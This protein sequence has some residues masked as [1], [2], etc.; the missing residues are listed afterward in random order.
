MP[1]SYASTLRR[2]SHARSR[3]DR[4]RLLGEGLGRLLAIETLEDRSLLSVN[5]VLISDAV[6]QAQQIRAAAAP[7]T[8]AIVYDADTVS[9]TGLINLLT[10]VSATHNGAL[11]G[12]LGIVAHGGPGEIDLGKGEDLNLAT[13]RSQA[14][15]L[16]GIRSVLTS[17]AT[18]E[19]YSC[20]V[21]AGPD[22]KTFVN[23]LATV[24][25]AAVFASDN[26]VGTVPGANFTWDYRTGQTVASNVLF[27]IP[28]LETIPRLCLLVDNAAFVSESPASGTSVAVNTSFTETVTMQNTGTTTW[29]AGANYYTLNRNPVGTDP[30]QQGSVYYA[31]LSSSVAPGGAG[32]ITI[33]L[34][35]PSSAGSYTETWQMSNASGSYFGGTATLTRTV[36]A[37]APAISG[38]SPSSYAASTNDQTMLINGSNFQS[39]ATVTFHDPQ[40]NSYLRTPTF[41]SSVQLSNQFDDNSD[42]GTW[43]V[44]VTNP[45][46]QT[47]STWSFAVTAAAPSISGLSPTTYPASTNNQTMLIN[48]SNFQSGATVTF[49][50][51]QGNSYLRTPTFVSSVQ[52]SNQFDDNSD[53]GTWTVFVTNPNGQ[54]SSTWSFAV[55]AA[56]AVN[57]RAFPDHVPGIDEQ[58]DDAHQR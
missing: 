57:Q 18:L 29:T 8:I 46:G 37:A 2:C 38:L 32:T 11:I 51:P 24:T 41:V 44:F 5:V 31:T 50:D 54:T 49:H 15:A 53:V 42:V 3:K 52:L 27:S 33:P 4:G 16:E 13:L 12:N 43:T 35:S 22:G 17:D 47:S 6:A 19:L 40:G 55:T 14:A 7:D 21:A 10:S 58:P 25:G 30:F 28:E 48:G 36:T 56:A 9:T 26:P 1:R 39:G 23:E 45:N 34:K 20:S